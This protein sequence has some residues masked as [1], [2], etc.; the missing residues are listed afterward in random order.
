MSKKFYNSLNECVQESIEGYIKINS[1]LKYMGDPRNQ[2]IVRHDIEDYI[3]SGKTIL[4]TGGGSG[5]EPAFLG[6]FLLLS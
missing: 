3:E 4:V 1:G 2:V 5:H 6:N